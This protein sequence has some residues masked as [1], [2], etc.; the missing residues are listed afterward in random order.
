MRASKPELGYKKE[1]RGF[2]PHITIG[3]GK[4]NINLEQLSGI[5]RGMGGRQW[6][7]QDV[8]CV[9]LYRSHL[10]SGGVRYEVLEKFPLQGVEKNYR[11]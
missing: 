11:L 2:T 7:T 3:R 10:E 4:G 9:I 8:K 5:L 1:K 6:G